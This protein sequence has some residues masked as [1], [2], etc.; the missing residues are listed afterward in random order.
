MDRAALEW[1]L[2]NGFPHGGWCPKARRAEDGPIPPQ[3]QLQETAAKSPV[4]RTRRNVRDS[5]GTVIFSKRP[6][7]S[8]GTAETSAFARKMG[9]PLLHL[10]SSMTIAEAAAV[11]NAFVTEHGITVLNV[12]GPRESE[13]GGN[14]IFVQA[15]L[16]RAFG[17]LKCMRQP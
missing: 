7:L 14:G 4:V 8:A 3:F 13:E 10:V 17:S 1:A 6:D 15:V 2:A 9:K 11:L 5:G 16:S 12:A